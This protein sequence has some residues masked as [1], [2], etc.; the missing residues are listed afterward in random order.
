MNFEMDKYCEIQIKRI[1][2]GDYKSIFTSWIYLKKLKDKKNHFFLSLYF[3]SVFLH[4]NIGKLQLS[5]FMGYESNM[6]LQKSR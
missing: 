1:R 4:I 2:N 3:F 5:K 6:G